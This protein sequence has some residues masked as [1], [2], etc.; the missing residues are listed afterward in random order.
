[1]NKKPVLLAVI[2]T[3]VLFSVFFI[4]RSL[5]P[6]AAPQPLAKTSLKVGYLPSL[7]AAPIFI[8]KQQGFFDR[9]NLNID[10]AQVFS[11]PDV[12]QGLQ[13]KSINVGF[14]VLP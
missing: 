11:G 6:A 8:A 13:S 3:V 4:W 5:Q 7:A 10:L 14:G 12:I 1:M 2:A 9:E